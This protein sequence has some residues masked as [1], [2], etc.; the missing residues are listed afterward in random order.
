MGGG[1]NGRSSYNCNRDL[2]LE[3]DNNSGI[4]WR[5]LKMAVGGSGGRWL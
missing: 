1:G 3:N 2:T 5:W 4:N